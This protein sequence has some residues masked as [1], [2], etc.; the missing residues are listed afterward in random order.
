MLG[1][2]TTSPYYER[3]DCTTVPASRATLGGIAGRRALA[4]VLTGGCCL[5]TAGG[6]A[7]LRE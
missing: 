5:S 6:G 1:R 3:E 7:S 4:R 2:Y